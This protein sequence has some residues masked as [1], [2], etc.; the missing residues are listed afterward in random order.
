MA[1]HLGRPLRSDESVHHRNL[2]K[3][4]NRIENLELWS[5]Y[6]PTGARVEDLLAWAW[7]IIRRH[8]RQAEEILAWEAFEETDRPGYAS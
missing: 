5:R 6:Q 8:D 4:D 1:R 7:E 3:S 2:Q